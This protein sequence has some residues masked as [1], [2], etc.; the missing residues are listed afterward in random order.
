MLASLAATLSTSS[1][2]VLHLL[3]LADHVRE[4]V[5]PSQSILELLML[6]AL[7]DAVDG[8][9]QHVD[10]T[11]L[12]H[13]ASRERRR[14]PPRPASTARV[15]VPWPP[16]TITSGSGSICL[17]RRSS[18]MPSM[19]GRDRSVST[20]SGRHCLKTS[21]PSASRPAPRARRSVRLRRRSEASRSSTAL[22]VDR[23]HSAA[24]SVRKWVRRNQQNP[25]G[26]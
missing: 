6:G 5:L 12:R 13:R 18:S 9:S 15:I 3:A 7:V 2:S 22:L 8:L 1:N 16:T 11:V 19:S 26:G 17:S 4:A 25:S 21:A 24:A 23:E 20:T 14:R 10:Q